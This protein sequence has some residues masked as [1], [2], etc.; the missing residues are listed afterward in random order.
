MLEHM[1]K[2][3]ELNEV[4][5]GSMR[6]RAELINEE[7]RELIRAL[8]YDVNKRGAVIST[9]NKQM[10][11]ADIVKEACDCHVVIS[12]VLVELGLTAEDADICQGIVDDN[13]LLKIATSPGR[14]PTGKLLKSADHPKCEPIIE[15][16]LTGIKDARLVDDYDGSNTFMA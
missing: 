12:G 7:C 5:D 9:P 14:G 6:L 8:G 15:E 16:Y 11:D 10:S 3:I 1:N 2:V 4:I 13:N